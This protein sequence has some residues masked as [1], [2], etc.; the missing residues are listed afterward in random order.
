M[1]RCGDVSHCGGPDVVR[2]SLGEL[3]TRELA[4]RINDGR[5]TWRA[6]ASKAIDVS[7]DLVWLLPV[8][9]VCLAPVCYAELSE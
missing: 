2:F 5:I 1:G 9:P 4:Q 6:S 3:P 8:A 7:H